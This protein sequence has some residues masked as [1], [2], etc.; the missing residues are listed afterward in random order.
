M[1]VG[2]ACLG[3]IHRTDSV[4]VNKT[5]LLSNG[6]T[7]LFKPCCDNHTVTQKEH[8][9]AYPGSD[10]NDPIFERKP[11]DNKQSLSIE[12]RQFIQQM[13]TGFCKDSKGNWSAS[14]PFCPDRLTLPN[15]RE[16]AQKGAKSLHISLQKNPVK[17]QHFVDF[18]GKM[19]ENNHAKVAPPLTNNEE[20]WCLPDFGV[21][22]PQKT[23][24]NS[25]CI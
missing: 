1:V 25:I 9:T 12:D 16:Q 2:E 23:Q 20:C 18:M 3:G 7:S 4:N 24:P 10:V 17:L 21:Y 8:I 15:N 19:F 6:R 13:D 14:L 5:F 22:H 11:D